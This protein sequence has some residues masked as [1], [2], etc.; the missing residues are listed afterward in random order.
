M[1]S[2]DSGA[3]IRKQMSLGVSTTVAWHYAPQTQFHQ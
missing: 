1:E 2:N 3:R